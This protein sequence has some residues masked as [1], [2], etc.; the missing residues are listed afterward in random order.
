MGRRLVIVGCSIVRSAADREEARADVHR[1]PQRATPGPLMTAP[2]RC[3]LNNAALLR[4][5]DGRDC[6][7]RDSGAEVTASPNTGGCDRQLCWE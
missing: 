6:D 1:N 3:I 4:R 7:F 2:K 5:T